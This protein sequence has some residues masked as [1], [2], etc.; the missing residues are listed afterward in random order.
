MKRPSDW[1]LHFVLYPM[2]F[3]ICPAPIPAIIQEMSNLYIVVCCK[4]L[5]Y[6]ITPELEHRKSGYVERKRRPYQG[7]VVR[8]A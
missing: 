3:R 6:N 4:D 2:I 7:N 8:I 5:R 1:P